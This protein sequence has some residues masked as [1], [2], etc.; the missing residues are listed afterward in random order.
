MANPFPG[1]DPYIESQGRWP[2]FHA[3]FLTY[4]R[5]ALL[6][7]L[8][9]HYEAR[10]DEQFRLVEVPVSSRPIEPDVAIL[11]FERPEA[12]RSAAEAE[13]G[14]AVLE[15]VTI[16]LP[17][18]VRVEH[19][20]RRI[21]ILRLPE[22]SLVTV[23]EVLSPTNK[24]QG[25]E[26]YLRKRVAIHE[27]EIHLVELDL[28]LAGQRLP[29]SEP[30]PPGDFYALV[31]RADRRPDCDVYAWPIRRALP[32]ALPIPLRAPDP[33]VPLD[34]AAVYATAHEKGRYA[35]SLDYAAP[36]A[37]PLAPE[38]RAWAESLAREAARR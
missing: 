35:R 33:D 11:R 16:P 9:G 4:L 10:I 23:I 12:G 28:L 31:A 21:E 19:T 18:I 5:D 1:V 2:D 3:S 20:E 26:D 24:A 32:N 13:A 36:L 14:V 37:L 8:P 30:L 34:L 6:D 17:E 25:R 7:R 15:P 29:M 22:R 27:Q 38:P